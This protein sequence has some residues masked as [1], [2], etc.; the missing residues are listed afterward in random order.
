MPFFSKI[1]HLNYSMIEAE[2]M[3]ALP[4]EHPLSLTEQVKIE[5]FYII[6]FYFICI[7]TFPVPAV[8]H[9]GAS[10]TF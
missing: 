10:V 5:S 9:M 4:L 7:S 8:L 2:H 6:L 3:N 1:L